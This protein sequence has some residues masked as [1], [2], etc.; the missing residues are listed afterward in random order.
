[1]T[2]VQTCALPIWEQCQQYQQIGYFPTVKIGKGGSC[3]KKQDRELR[4]MKEVKC[5]KGDKRIKNAERI[6]SAK[7]AQE[8]KAGLR[9]R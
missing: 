2:G 9:V 1:M 4:M 5:A 7:G 3:Q 8:A 6:K